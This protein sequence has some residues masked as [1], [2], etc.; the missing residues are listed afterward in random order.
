MERKINKLYVP[1]A[2]Q[3]SLRDKWNLNLNTSRTYYTQ[4]YKCHENSA[5][6]LTDSHYLC[7]PVCLH[8]FFLSGKFKTFQPSLIPPKKALNRWIWNRRKTNDQTLVITNAFLNNY[9]PKSHKNRIWARHENF[10]KSIASQG[11]DRYGCFWIVSI[12][13]LYVDI[14]IS[15]NS[16]SHCVPWSDFKRGLVVNQSPIIFTLK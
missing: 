11:K 2:K 14:T 10:E 6:Y 9:P 5:E 4:T 7:F 8:V 16:D 3:F 13:Y 15:F 12:Q 1:W